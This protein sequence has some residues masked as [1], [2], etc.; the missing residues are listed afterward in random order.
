MRR[1]RLLAYLRRVTSRMRRLKSTHWNLSQERIPHVHRLRFRPYRSA[2]FRR[3]RSL[4]GRPEAARAAGGAGDLR[5]HRRPD[6]PK[7][8][9]RAVRV[10][11]RRIPARGVGDHRR[12]P[13]DE[14]RRAVSRAT[15]QQALAKFRPDAAAQADVVQRFI[16]R[17]F[18]HCADFGKLE[19]MLGLRQR[20]EDLEHQRRLPGN[21]LFYLATDPDF[22]APIVDSLSSAGMV[23]RARR[24][25]LE[26]RGHREAVRPRSGHG[27]GA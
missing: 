5:R 26:T 6:G 13:A 3:A 2:V 25:G 15:S 10:A 21:R 18:Y 16:A 23:A 1:C 11:P 19:G 8:P 14:E 20:I 9:A 24:P 27:A 4:A 22:F 7:A 12:R 17:M